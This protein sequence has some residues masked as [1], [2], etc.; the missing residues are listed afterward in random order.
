MFFSVFS[1]IVP[2]DLP[3]SP[4][5]LRY[6]IPPRERDTTSANTQNKA[7][8]KRCWKKKKKS[9][10]CF[11]RTAG[12]SAHLCAE[13]FIGYHRNKNPVLFASVSL[14]HSSVSHR[15]Q[16][17]WSVC[18]SWIELSCWLEFDKDFGEILDV[19]SF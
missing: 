1:N 16:R 14:V 4:I 2:R 10:V 19:F 15:K 3:L 12:S 18:I 17:G 6:T 7:T 8:G 11:I 9:K 13:F 5:S